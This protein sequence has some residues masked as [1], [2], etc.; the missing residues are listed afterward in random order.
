MDLPTVKEIQRVPARDPSSRHIRGMGVNE[1][2][3][4]PPNPFASF[5]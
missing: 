3:L 5:G 4:P 2:Q 1:L